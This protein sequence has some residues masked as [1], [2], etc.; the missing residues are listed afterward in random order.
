MESPSLSRY[1]IWLMK[2]SRAAERARGSQC[3][4]CSRTPPHPVAKNL[5]TQAAKQEG[6]PLT[7]G[8]RLPRKSLE[9]APPRLESYRHDSPGRSKGE[10]RGR[11]YRFSAATVAGILDSDVRP[12]SPRAVESSKLICFRSFES[13]PAQTPDNP[14]EIILIHVGLLFF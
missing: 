13:S 12:P 1:A 10:M 5:L 4:I 2:A 14:I 11:R 7:T 9:P 8:G 6:G 3:E